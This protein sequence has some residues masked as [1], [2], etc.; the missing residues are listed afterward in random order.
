MATTTES[1]LSRLLEDLK[2]DLGGDL[3]AVVLYGS[4]A[5]GEH[6]GAASN[7]NLLVVVADDSPQRIVAAAKTQRHWVK[8]GHPPLL[9]VTPEWIRCSTDVFPMEF[10][11]LLDHRKILAGDDPLAGVTVSSENLRLQCEHEI[12]SILLKLR[13]SWLD[14]HG[15]AREIFRLVTGS[16]GP[17]AAVARAALRLS[18]ERVP[19]RTEEAF[20][21]VARRFGLE[22]SKLLAGAALKKSGREGDLARMKEV[23]LAY[24][25]QIEAL[26]RALDTLPADAGAR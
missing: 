13:A 20:E 5:R 17:V 3:L 19:P 9:F 8:A 1:I 2:D 24:F 6:A 7:L 14:A 26:G 16:L 15:D 22:A 4:A 23:F 10:L 18:G 11:D 25:S 21:A 12:R